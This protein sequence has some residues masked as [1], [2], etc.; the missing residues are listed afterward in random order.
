MCMLR[1]EYQQAGF[2]HAAY[3]FVVQSISF[4]LCELIRP[5]FSLARC[6][7]CDFPFPGL[8]PIVHTYLD[9]IKCDDAT[10]QVVNQYMLLIEKRVKGT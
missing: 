7:G 5:L 6:Q 1:S 10:R 8:I 3:Y 9:L 4:A 2:V